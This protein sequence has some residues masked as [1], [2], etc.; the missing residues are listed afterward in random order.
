MTIQKLYG[1]NGQVTAIR[2][3]PEA[4]SDALRVS[5]QQ[6]RDW[7][8]AIP[9][10]DTGQGHAPFYQ[11]EN[12]AQLKIYK[13][14]AAVLRTHMTEKAVMNT[15]KAGLLDAYV[16]LAE[17]CPEGVTAHV[18]RSYG[19]I[20]LLQ[21]KYGI[22]VDSKQLAERAGLSADTAS[23]HIRL[24]AAMGFL[25]DREDSWAHQGLPKAFQTK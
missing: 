22:K 3:S 19:L 23:K 8:T 9:L 2:M 1:P 5:R 13:K 17:D 11:I 7:A 4:M 25:T 21:A 20:V 10:T 14:R 15:E 18:W 24:L 16:A 6:L 12:P